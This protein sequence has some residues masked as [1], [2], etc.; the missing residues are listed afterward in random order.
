VR[1]LSDSD[2]EVVLEAIDALE[3]V[4][5]ENVAGDLRRLSD[6]PNQEVREAAE[7]ALEYLQED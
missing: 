1:A 2:P 4:G 3:F 7:D 5:D 6:H